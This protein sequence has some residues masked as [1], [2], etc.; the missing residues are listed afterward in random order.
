MRPRRPGGSFR[1]FENTEREGEAVALER[2]GYRPRKQLAKTRRRFLTVA[3]LT[4]QK[5]PSPQ[6]GAG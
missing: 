1:G 5:M 6:S 4:E 2:C 3:A